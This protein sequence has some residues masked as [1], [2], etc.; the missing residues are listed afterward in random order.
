MTELEKNIFCKEFETD[1][2]LYDASLTRDTEEEAFQLYKDILSRIEKRDDIDIF[3]IVCLISLFPPPRNCIY[4][5]SHGYTKFDVANFTVRPT[6][7]G[8]KWCVYLGSPR[9]LW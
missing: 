4:A 8:K 9:K 3:E 5:L 1:G 7:D 6:D 2:E